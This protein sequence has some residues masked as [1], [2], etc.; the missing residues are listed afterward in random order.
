MVKKQNETDYYGFTND[1]QYDRTL[2][3][4]TKKP[5]KNISA[6]ILIIIIIF[7]SIIIVTLLSFSGYIA[8]NAYQND[9][10]GIKL[11]KTYLAILFAPFYLIYS[12]VYRLI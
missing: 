5:T 3:Y 1:Y 2:D 11:F 7:I 12:K 4:P 10:I 9:S 8:W 6:I